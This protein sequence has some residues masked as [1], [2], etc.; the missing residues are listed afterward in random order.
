M[1]EPL[2]L[3]LLKASAPDPVHDWVNRPLLG[4]SE[5]GL[6]QVRAF[7]HR[8]E[9]MAFG[10]VRPLVIGCCKVRVLESALLKLE[11]AHVHFLPS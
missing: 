5:I 11:S 10:E 4:R 2:E 6:R 9:H 8:L 1:K 3:F 7:E